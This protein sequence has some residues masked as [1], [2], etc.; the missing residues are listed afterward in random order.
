M[1]VDGARS[2]SLYLGY[3]YTTSSTSG[4]WNAV[5]TTCLSAPQRI[6]GDPQ[7]DFVVVL[8]TEIK[9]GSKQGNKKLESFFYAEASSFIRIIDISL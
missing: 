3:R 8:I 6:V 5:A 2:P 7:N 4:I 9:V 1:C